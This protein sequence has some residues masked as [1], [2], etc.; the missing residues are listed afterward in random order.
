[1]PVKTPEERVTTKLSGNSYVT[2]RIRSWAAEQSPPA[3]VRRG[4]KSVAKLPIVLPM[5]CDHGFT[6]CATRKCVESWSC[7]W[8]LYLSNTKGGRRLIEQLQ[9]TDQEVRNLCDDEKRPINERSIRLDQKEV[10][11]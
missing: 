1:M 11:E 10:T 5:H 9:L 7:D 3:P 8:N 2:A 6:I 4:R